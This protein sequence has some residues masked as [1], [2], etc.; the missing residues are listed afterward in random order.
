[1]TNLEK[2]LLL[3]NANV[4]DGAKGD[5]GDRGPEGPEGPEG[6]QGETGASNVTPEG[7]EF[8]ILMNK[9]GGL[10]VKGTVVSASS[11]TDLAVQ[12]I[13][14]GVPDPIG[15]IYEDGIADGEPVKVV[16]SGIADVLYIGSATRKHLARGFL[17]GENGYVSGQ[18]LSEAVPTSPF[19][20]DKHFYEIGHVLESREGAGLA[21]TMLHF[22]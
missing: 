2:L 19:A 10:S 1:M 14:E 18:A 5:Q 8:V 13:V 22:N 21:K 15:V 12:K 17:T 4:Q 16:K 20:S 11:T 9:T 6:P 7:G 3:K